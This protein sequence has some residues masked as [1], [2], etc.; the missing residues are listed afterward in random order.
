MVKKM[1]SKSL[2]RYGYNKNKP[3]DERN[4]NPHIYYRFCCGFI[5]NGNRNKPRYLSRVEKEALKAEP[6]P[7][8]PLASYKTPGSKMSQRSAE[9][10][11]PD[12]NEVVELGG[13][14]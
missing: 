3:Y 5:I 2:R 8:L 12:L 9:V 13:S 11:H 14:L 4:G 6:Y 7:T 1:Q 10:I